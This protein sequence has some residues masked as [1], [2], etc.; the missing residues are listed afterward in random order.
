MFTVASVTFLSGP[1]PMLPMTD[2]DRIAMGIVWA[3]VS[4]AFFGGAII[5]HVADRHL[6]PRGVAVL[7]ACVCMEWQPGKLRLSGTDM[8]KQLSLEIPAEVAEPGALA[9]NF[10]R[11]SRYVAL[12]REPEVR[13]TPEPGAMLLA[14]GRSR[15]KLPV[16]DA[17]D[18]PRLNDPDAV[19]A[20]TMSADTL[21]AMAAFC[22]DAAGV[23]E[24]RFYLK[25]IWLDPSDGHIAIA[26]DGHV[27]AVFAWP[28]LSGAV[29]QTEGP[30]PT[31]A[32][33]IAAGV[34]DGDVSV[35][36]TDQKA[37]F[38]WD[39]GRLLS[40]MI[41]GTFPTQWRTGFPLN[42][43]KRATAGLADMVSAVGR[44]VGASG[45]NSL[46][47][48]VSDEGIEINARDYATG[49]EASDH[50][51]CA[52]DERIAFAIDGGY[53][54]DALAALAARK[55]G[56]TLVVRWFDA[57]RPFSFALE[58]DDAVRVIS[59]QR[60]RVVSAEAA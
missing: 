1:M 42:A 8:D 10:E 24:H 55:K 22:S 40:K 43:P 19:D 56:D 50:I 26:S 46:G 37:E 44:V 28:L 21:R 12:S 6:P 13:L 31:A 54:R 52:A 34:A 49:R 41:N 15:L 51:A 7:K 36:L 57:G 60:A 30:I 16:L 9:A 27:G 20:F 5:A 39:G 23:E 25:G 11:L 38:T 35:R 33:E 48:I 58:G 53:L 17:A 45:S 4:L 32:V 2:G 14:A 18:W 47:I 3:G 29:P 59:P